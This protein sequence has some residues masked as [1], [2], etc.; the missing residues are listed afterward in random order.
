MGI[1]LPSNENKCKVILTTRDKVLCQIADS[2]LTVSTQYLDLGE[3]NLLS[4]S[5]A[6]NF[7][8]SKIEKDL[9][10][11]GE[12][13]VMHAR[14]MVERCGGLPLALTLIGSSMA[15]AISIN[16]WREA[17]RN[18]SKSPPAIKGVAEDHELLHLLDHGFPGPG[19]KLDGT[20]EVESLAGQER[21]KGYLK[22]MKEFLYDEKVR[23]LGIHGM[24]RVG[25]TTL[26]RIFNNNIV[27]SSIARRFDRI[28][29]IPVS[30]FPSVEEIK[31]DI[32]EQTSQNLSSLSESRFLILLD[33]VRQEMDLMSIGIQK[34][35][36]KVIM[37]DRSKSNCHITHVDPT[38]ATQFIEVPTLTE[39]EAWIFFQSIVGTE[40][41]DTEGGE[42]AKLAKIVANMCRGIPLTLEAIGKRMKGASSLY[43]WSQAERIL[44]SNPPTI[45][46]VAT[47]VLDL[48]DDEIQGL[49]QEVGTL[50]GE[51]LAGQEKI[52]NYLMQIKEFLDDDES[53]VLGIYG[54]GGIGKTTLLNIFN[55][56]VVRINARR[57]LF[58]HII[59]IT[60]SQVVN[61]KKIKGD[62][63]RQIRGNLSSLS[64]S[65]FLLLLDN[66]WNEV[67]LSVLGI[68][69]PLSQS[70]SKVIMTGRSKSY[71]R[72]RHVDPNC[73]QSFEVALLTELEAWIFFQ[74]KLDKNLE[75]KGGEI[76]QLAKSVAS[77]LITCIC[78]LNSYPI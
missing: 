56:K 63:T 68:L 76:V 3:V 66:V 70:R 41:L 48:L 62:I 75:R 5:E 35:R 65:K 49:G 18:L 69:I 43:L 8:K 33:D 38:D 17:E 13:T 34:D 55:D 6:W 10:Q 7:F 58:D 71:C 26:L 21:M 46:G 14:K 78:N 19:K 39:S 61:I 54:M 57:R 40:G 23:V 77:K 27:G 52:N 53:R 28:I 51:S 36:C 9:D 11:E 4:E 2:S 50:L 32:E 47:D 15:E 37:T 72:V 73:T 25:K 22:Q 30:Q 74:K 20:P 16:E 67:D 24:G 64:K 45:E 60:M 42:I 1:P 29:F 31:R 59:F 44:K 12:E